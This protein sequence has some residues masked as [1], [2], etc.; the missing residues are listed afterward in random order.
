MDLPQHDEEF[1]ALLDVILG[2]APRHYLEIGTRTGGSFWTIGQAL[3]PGA[4][5]ISVDLPAGPWGLVGSQ[6]AKAQ[7]ADAL[8]ARGQ[9][10]VEIEGD[11]H[12]RDVV[13]RVH[14][15]LG[16]RRLDLLFIDGDHSLEGVRADWEHYA[17][18]VRGGGLVVFHDLIL[19]DAFPECRVGL[20][21]QELAPRFA[22]R[23]V[24]EQ[25]GI[26]WLRLPDDWA[27]HTEEGA[28]MTSAEANS[29]GP[30]DAARARLA[31]LQARSARRFVIF[32][33]GSAG[34]L[35]LDALAAEGVVTAFVDNDERKWGTA[36][37]GIPV[38]APATLASDWPDTVVVASAPAAAAITAQL[39]GL[40]IG[41]HRIHV[42][43]PSTTAL[44]VQGLGTA[45]QRVSA[46]V[47]VLLE[48]APGVGR[49]QRV[50]VFGT[51]AGGR[52]AQARLRGRHHV[53]AFADNDRAKVG[54]SMDGVPIVAADQIGTLPFD[55]I[56]IASVHGE[57]IRA[58]LRGLGFDA[59][60]LR[61]V[62][63]VLRGEDVA[64]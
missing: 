20:L 9:A 40:G 61:T 31:R 48:M 4:L 14:Q 25:Y 45:L 10:V 17:P 16:P 3:A 11:S 59:A 39:V 1:A 41:R 32:G 44:Q 15:A 22:S 52:E 34:R 63:Q 62:D 26:G 53:V 13:A 64:G 50:V 37:A 33:A 18:L 57:A 47:T 6:R 19:S 21:W 23:A 38:V 36:I 58:Q 55:A 30:L 60:R 7:V 2:E 56:V 46:Q 54:Q 42:F 49:P 24:V 29:T 5:M 12:D 28:G 43:Q 27:G 8:R 51:G 35:A